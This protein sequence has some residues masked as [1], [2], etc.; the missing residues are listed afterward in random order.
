M[1][2]DLTPPH[3]GAFGPPKGI[4]IKVEWLAFQ[5]WW[6]R[7]CPDRDVPQATSHIFD[8]WLASARH[9]EA[10]EKA[11]AKAMQ[12]AA[13]HAMMAWGASGRSSHQSPASAIAALDPAQIA[14]G[15][16]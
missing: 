6:R 11:G 5:A 16:K 7:W 14:G 15:A 4:D 10:A 8:A 2:D 9:R 3:W 12:E 1:T 13:E